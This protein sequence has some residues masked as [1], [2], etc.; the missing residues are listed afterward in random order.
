MIFPDGNTGPGGSS[1][2]PDLSGLWNIPGVGTLSGGCCVC[3]V[4]GGSGTDPDPLNDGNPSG[5]D[6]FFKTDASN[7]IGGQSGGWDSVNFYDYTG[8]WVSCGVD[9]L[10]E[11]CGSGGVVPLV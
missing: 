7:G 4:A 2:G 8:Q 9:E 3:C 11:N 10:C 1:T 5:A 6:C